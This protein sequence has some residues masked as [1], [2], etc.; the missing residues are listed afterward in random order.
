[1]SQGTVKIKLTFFPFPLY[2]KHIECCCTNSVSLLAPPPH[3][4][5]ALAS[6]AGLAKGEETGLM[7]P[8][9]L[10]PQ[11]PRCS[12]DGA[13]CQP[14]TRA[15]DP[16]ATYSSLSDGCQPSWLPGPHPSRSLSHSVINSKGGKFP[17]PPATNL[18]QKCSELRHQD[19]ELRVQ[20]GLR[21][22]H[23]GWVFEAG[24]GSA[25]IIHSF[26]QEVRAEHSLSSRP[27]ETAEGSCTGSPSEEDA[28]R[29]QATQHGKNRVLEAFTKE[30]TYELGR[31]FAFLREGRCVPGR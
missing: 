12:R 6:R 23:L 11:R 3:G 1:M 27:V 31:Q 13:K 17:H 16:L 30:G 14:Q 4:F 2:C 28:A 8:P 20:L 5:L 25:G 10:N 7:P 9:Q 21:L 19:P 18:W 26:G 15:H 29:Q 22:L 24:E